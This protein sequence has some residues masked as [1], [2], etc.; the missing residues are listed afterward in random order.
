M[1]KRHF[2][3]EEIDTLKKNKYVKRVG[4]KGIT[5]TD[6]FKVFAITEYEK[7]SVSTVI[8]EKA[9][10]NTAVLGES[11]VY[12]ALKRWRKAYRN[13]GVMGLRDRRK[14]RSGRPR[15]RTLSSEQRLKRQEAR[16]KYLEM[17][18]EFQ[19]KLDMIERGVNID[20]SKKKHD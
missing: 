13:N 10:F 2:T 15:E 4:P 17:E 9:G 19:K 11:R 18:L 6:E 20:Q 16:I 1:S 7:G 3:K 8:F 5:Y 12:G 14:G